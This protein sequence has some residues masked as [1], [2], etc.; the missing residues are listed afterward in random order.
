MA[1]MYRARMVVLI[2][3]LFVDIYTRWSLFCTMYQRARQLAM[4][5]VRH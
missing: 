1:S 5:A 2:P 3:G 4:D